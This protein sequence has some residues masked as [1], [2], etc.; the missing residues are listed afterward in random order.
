MKPDRAPTKLMAVAI[1]GL[2]VG[3]DPT[4][5]FYGALFPA[6]L[7]CIFVGV[8]GAAILRPFLAWSG[9]EPHLAPLAIVYP[10]LAALIGC[11]VWLWL[12]K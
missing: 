9:I 5:N 12:F 11:V 4:L 8:A 7:I 2:P 6:W 10:A 1:A 3:C